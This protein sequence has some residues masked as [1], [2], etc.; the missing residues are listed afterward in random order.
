MNHPLNVSLNIYIYIY[1][2]KCLQEHIIGVWYIISIDYYFMD[3]GIKT[4]YLLF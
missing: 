1:L 2:F 4:E 3:F